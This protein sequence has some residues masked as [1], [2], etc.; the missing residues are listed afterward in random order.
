MTFRI[1]MLKKPLQQ[2][3]L[4]EETLEEPPMHLLTTNPL[5]PKPLNCYLATITPLD[6][7]MNLQDC[8]LTIRALFPNMAYFLLIFPCSYYSNE[9]AHPSTQFELSPLVYLSSLPYVCFI[10]KQFCVE[11]SR[12]RWLELSRWQPLDYNTFLIL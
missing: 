7:P 4:C 1:Y 12:W 3:A 10:S 9:Y 11:L 2:L 5:L 6:T 8:N